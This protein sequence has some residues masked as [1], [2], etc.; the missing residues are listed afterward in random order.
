MVGLTS[1][2]M[3]SRGRSRA[4]MGFDE[5]LK[6]LDRYIAKLSTEFDRTYEIRMIEDQVGFAHEPYVHSIVVSA[7]T[8]GAVVQIDKI[9]AARSIPPL[10][11]YKVDMVLDDEGGRISSTRVSV[12]EI[13][14]EGKVG[15][16]SE[17]LEVKKG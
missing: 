9:R 5:R 8:E 11:V 16:R 7:E 12:G 6:I 2:V 13:D 1:D 14:G 10:C 15:S 17:G 3:A 4:V